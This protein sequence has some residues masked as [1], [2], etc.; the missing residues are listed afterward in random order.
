MNEIKTII[1]KEFPQIV[2]PLIDSA[3]K[4]IKVVVFDWRWYP[5]DPANPVQ[6]FN[7]AF[8]RAA[9]RGVEIEAI[10]NND[11]IVKTLLDQGIKAKRVLLKTIIHSKLIIIDGK[12]VVI[13]SHNYTQSAFTFNQEISVAISDCSDI[14]KFNL[15]FHNLYM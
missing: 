15:F 8:V 1:G 3:K 4:S 6:L 14:D 9:R 5:Q 7:Q 11:E 12:I 10:A 13:G 2:V